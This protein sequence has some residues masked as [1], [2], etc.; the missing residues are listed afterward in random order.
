MPDENAPAPVEESNPGEV[1]PQNPP[2]PVAPPAAPVAP[3]AAPPPAARLVVS[4]VKS[5]R[6]IELEGL[7]AERDEKLT[8]AERRALEAER[9][10]AEKERENQHLKSVSRVQRPKKERNYFGPVIGMDDED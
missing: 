10:A 4:G 9:L 8:A 6:E 2:P 1:A 5:E 7:L 3:H